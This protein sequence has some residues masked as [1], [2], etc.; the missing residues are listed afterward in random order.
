MPIIMR[1]LDNKG[2]MSFEELCE[3]KVINLLHLSVANHIE[4]SGICSAKYKIINTS[5]I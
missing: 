5:N 3:L 1:S 4:A 2:N